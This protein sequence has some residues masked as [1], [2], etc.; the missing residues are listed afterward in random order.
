MPKTILVIDDDPDLLR[1]VHFVLSR[2]GYVVITATTGQ[3]GLR[4]AYANHPDLIILDIMMPQLDG[5]Q[6]CTRLRHIC[7]TPIIILT[8]KTSKADLQRSFALGA[9]DYLTKP[10]DFGELKARLKARLRR[11]ESSPTPD[12]YDDDSL[13]IDLAHG[14]VSRNGQDVSLTPTE[15][16]LL[17]YLVHQR[18][19]VISHE[20]LIHHVWGENRE[21]D[22]RSLNVYIHYLRHKIEEDPQRPKY[23]CTS[24]GRGYY[25]TDHEPP[26]HE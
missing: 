10:C 14:T 26:L 5:W 24:W 1:M 7:D 9:D 18:G 20:Q 25:F 21:K 3:E 16:R 13:R 4:Q 2:E 23:L 8:A 15:Q 11:S 22:T 19:R 17:F 12:V 6:L